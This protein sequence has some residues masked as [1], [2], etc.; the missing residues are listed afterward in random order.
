MLPADFDDGERAVGNGPPGGRPVARGDPLREVTPVEEDH[1]VRRG[2][3][4][5][6]PA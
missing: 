5:G 6:A 2:V 3:G 1:R 4:V